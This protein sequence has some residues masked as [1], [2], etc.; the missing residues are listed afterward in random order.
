MELK[1]RHAFFFL[2]TVKGKPKVNFMAYA[3]MPTQYALLLDTGGGVVPTS[4]MKKTLAEIHKKHTLYDYEDYTADEMYALFKSKVSTFFNRKWFHNRYN[5]IVTQ[6]LITATPKAFDG[7]FYLDAIDNKPKVGVMMYK[8]N[9]SGYAVNFY[10]S[11]KMRDLTLNADQ[12]NSAMASMMKRL[13]CY[14][15]N[16]YT[17][18]KLHAIFKDVPAKYDLP[19]FE[20]QYERIKKFKAS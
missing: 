14:R 17:P 11:G 20:E 13:K 8:R 2:D 7:L 10:E 9:K 18:A 16:D 4:Q 12:M 19:W 6:L 15:Y 3:K 1:D 5:L